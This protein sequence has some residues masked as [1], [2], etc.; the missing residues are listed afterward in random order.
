MRFK[1]FIA[2]SGLL[3][4]LA[5]FIAGPAFGQATPAEPVKP[6]CANCHETSHE[7]IAQTP[8]GVKNDA[9][10]SMCI[11]CHGDAAE[12]LKDPMKAKMT[13]KFA[14]GIP[15]A[16]KDAI[17]LT[18]HANNRH[19]GFWESGKHALNDV[20]CSDCHNVHGRPKA[21]AG[22][23]PF[24]TSQRPNEADMCGSCHKQIRSATLKPSH[25]PIMEGKVKCSDCHNPHGALSQA[26]VKQESVNQ[27]C[28]SCHA[29]KRG[30]YVFAHPVVEENCLTC[31]NPHGSSHAKLL[32][33]KVPNLCQDCHIQGRHPTSY[34]GQ[35]KGWNNPD[36]TPNAAV[37]SRF[38]ARA[39]LNC[40]NAIHGSNA[41]ATRGQ[42]LIR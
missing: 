1:S 39:C 11:A 17:C 16:Q 30:P 7:S 41:P 19:L 4:A 33:E 15:A 13:S 18:C 14:K 5:A 38:V 20:T 35:E 3:A 24:S 9:S 12:H 2:V 26:M 8:H 42:F 40:H 28:F 21:L 10:G 6:V 22:A 27:Q 34:Y 25:H 29:D 23:A 36:G 32:N 31:H 37:S